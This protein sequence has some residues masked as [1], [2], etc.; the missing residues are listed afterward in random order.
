MTEAGLCFTSGSNP[1][2]AT[3]VQRA[4]LEEDSDEA[5]VDAEGLV[6][7]G[8]SSLTVY[9][10]NGQY[11]QTIPLQMTIGIAGGVQTISAV[12]QADWSGIA[13]TCPRATGDLLS[14][15]YLDWNGAH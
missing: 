6:V 11:N 2:A 13:S 4:A 5:V 7:T 14:Q 9:W 8:D 15:V 3:A 10:G 12:G 1:L